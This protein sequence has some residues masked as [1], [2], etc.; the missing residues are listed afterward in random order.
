MHICI[1]SSIIVL[2]L[3]TALLAIDD[4]I[5]VDI[6][7]GP[8]YLGYSLV[9]DIFGIVGLIGVGMAIGHRWA[10]PRTAWLPTWEDWLIVGGLGILLVSGFIVEGLRIHTSEIHVNPEWSL[11]VARGWIVAKIFSGV[12]STPRSICTA[13]SGGS[14]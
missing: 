12:G 11:L 8:R 10:R 4:Y 9:A 5:P 2:F 13:P 6:L 1:M 7:V 14:T 3:V